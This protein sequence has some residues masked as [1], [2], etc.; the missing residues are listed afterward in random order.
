M[1]NPNVGDGRKDRR[2]RRRDVVIVGF[3]VNLA[4]L[5]KASREG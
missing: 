5:H 2:A 4:T 1:D 3:L